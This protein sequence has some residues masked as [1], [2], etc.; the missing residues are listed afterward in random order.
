MVAAALSSLPG[1]PGSDCVLLDAH[2]EMA[3][4]HR[5]AGGHGEEGTTARLVLRSGLRSWAVANLP[6]GT[7]ALQW[8]KSAKDAKS[9][10]MDNVAATMCVGLS[11]A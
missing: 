8:H 10:G 5:E 1:G 6:A 7:E 11:S 3:R 4:L 2:A 9:A